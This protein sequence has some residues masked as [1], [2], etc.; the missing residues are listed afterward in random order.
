MSGFR[1]LISDAVSLENVDEA[2]ALRNTLDA[3]TIVGLSQAEQVCA[4]IRCSWHPGSSTVICMEWMMGASR[5]QPAARTDSQMQWPQRTAVLK[6]AASR[7]DRK[8]AT[9]WNA[10]C[11]DASRSSM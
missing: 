8:R 2:E 1:Y 3:M 11:S 10:A 7:K 6:D 4:L 5:V 9:C